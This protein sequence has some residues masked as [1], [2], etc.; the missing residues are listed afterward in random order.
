MAEE[1]LIWQYLRRWAEKFPHKEALIFKD[2]RITY[3]EFYGKT[4]KVA[5][6]L[7]ELGVK[8]GDRVF[9]LCAARDEFF[10]TYMATAMVGGI[11]FGLNPRYTRDEF[12]YMVGD[13]KPR[14]GFV[15][16][17]YDAL[18][19]DYMEDV[20]AL[21][22]AN[23]ELKQLVIIDNP[24]EGTLNW[25]AELAK[26]PGN[27]D[28]A[29]SKRMEEV[30]EDDPALIIYTS[31]T[32]GKPKG[33][34]LTHKNIIA[35]A[36]AQNERFLAPTNKRG[37]GKS[38]I[39]FPINHVACAVE[40]AMGG[41]HWGSPIVLMDR[42]DPAATL[43]TIQDEKVTFMGQVPAM[44]M[45]QFMLPDYDSYDQSSLKTIIWAGSAASEEM[46]KR[47][48]KTG[49]TL[50]T[51][52]GQTENAGFITYSKPG[53]SMEDLIQTAGKCYPPFQ[54]KLVDK[55]GKEVPEGQ[56]GEIWMKG[57]LIM[58]GYWNRPEATAETLT[59]D[60]WLKSGDL[61]T[62]DSRGYIKIVGR[63]KE[64][65]KSGGYNVY[66]REIEAVIEQHPGVAFVTVIPIPDETW[67]EVGKA[68]IMPV[69]GKTVDADEVRELCK[70]HL[71]N[72][73]IP[74]QIEVRPLLPLLASGKVDRRALVEEVKASQQ[75]K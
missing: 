44:F 5:K 71:A 62:M 67:Q 61:A 22:V 12:L 25:E 31:G 48:S 56:V 16:R 18:M 19:R 57:D 9:T 28:A 55:D 51:G 17:N 69:P 40:L 39:H 11:W 10:Y 15:V 21:K 23:P 50:M 6:L 7:L 63:I 30:N 38:L 53:D 2:R 1:K 68:F 34:L 52:Y 3:K 24:W 45:L 65:F 32:T 37:E 8:K 59:K 54:I 4:L 29:L 14:V 47:L 20:I 42:F 35:S 73:K 74:K 26:Y 72:Y 13:A 60:G 41:L 46:V 75:K 70:K 36:A 33:A 66:P 58:K 49:A 27:L 64:M 43:K